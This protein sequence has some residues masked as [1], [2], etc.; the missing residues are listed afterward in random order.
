MLI[1]IAQRLAKEHFADAVPGPAPLVATQLRDV[2]TA[3]LDGWNGDQWEYL[4][5]VHGLESDAFRMAEWHR[6]EEEEA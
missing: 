5:H 3:I 6:L 4:G 2:E 1:E